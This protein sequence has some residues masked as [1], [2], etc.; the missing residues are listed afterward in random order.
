MAT[1][2]ELE[3]Q[4]AELLARLDQLLEHNMELS[5]QV[6][7][8]TKM[9]FGSRSEKTR[10]SQE[11]IPQNQTEE[12]HHRLEE[13][14]CL[15]CNGEM[16]EL[17]TKDWSEVKL[18]PA[19][20]VRCRHI[21]HRYEC[22]NC[23]KS[24]TNQIRVAP[25]PKRALPGSI[26]SPS[27]ITE[28]VYMK[29]TQFV[30]LERQLKDWQRLGL[31][32]HSRTLNEWVNK[33]AEDWLAPI[34]QELKKQLLAKTILAVDET[35]SRILRRSDGKSGRSK[36][37][38]WVYRTIEGATHPITLFDSTLTRSRDEL[39]KFLGNWLGL[40]LCDG[41]SVYRQLPG[42]CWAHARRKWVEALELGGKASSPAVR[43]G[44]MVCDA[45]FRMERDWQEMPIMARD[46]LRQKFARPLLEDFY[47]WLETQFAAPK[48]AL[49]KAITYCLNQK[50]GLLKFLEVPAL[51][52]HNNGAENAIRPLTLG[53]KNWLFSTSEAGG[54]ANAIYLSLVETCKANHI[55][56][57]QYL[58]KLLIELPEV[59]LIQEPEKINNYLP[60]SLAIIESC[61]PA[62][63][64][65]KAA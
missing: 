31:T 20:L 30:P 2:T 28:A 17:G 22:R 65:K 40:I 57:R 19:K 21:V 13:P 52:I 64:M 45:L 18:I 6:A 49:D 51:P 60:W 58:E 44:K 24:G 48:S 10:Y 62:K 29:F 5:N 39:R 36:S 61:Q 50:A 59:D 63:N 55:D 11:E 4:N 37:Q 16:K 53:K 7:N 25:S 9:L 46:Q 3:E 8:L 32:L 15:C 42:H 35:P 23:K 1:N 34:Y 47:R 41:Y 12:Y 38:N 56:F 26:A 27:M 33:V 14:V 43:L 54:K